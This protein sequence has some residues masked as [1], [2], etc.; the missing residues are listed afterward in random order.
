VAPL[1]SVATL[2]VGALTTVV[3]LP[4]LLACSIL[5]P[6]AGGCVL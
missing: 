2:V 6:A 1:L 3:V 5:R 4:L